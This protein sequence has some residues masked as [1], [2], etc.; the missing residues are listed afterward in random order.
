MWSPASRRRDVEGAR[1]DHDGDLALVVQVAAGS[2]T[3][4]VAAVAVQRRHG[5][6]EVR[7]RRAERRLELRATA[8]IV[9]MHADDLARLGRRQVVRA[10][11]ATRSP[12]TV[13]R[14]FPSRTTVVGNPWSAILRV[15]MPRR[16]GA[17]P[18][19][20]GFWY[21]RTPRGESSLDTAPALALLRRR[22]H[23]RVPHRS[24]RCRRVAAA[25]HRTGRRRSR[26]RRAG[27]R[28]LAIVRRRRCR[29]PRPGALPVQGGVRRRPLPAWGRDLLALCLDLGRQGF[30]ARARLVPGLPQEA[31]IDLDDAAGHGR[32]SRPEARARR[33]VRGDARRERPSA[34]RR[35]RHVDAG[36]WDR[37]LRERT[38]DAAFPM[39]AIDRGRW[40]GR[41]RRPRDDAVRRRGGRPGV[42]RDRHLALYDTRGRSSRRSG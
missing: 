5:L 36:G 42:A 15:S 22:P 13:T 40:C 34:R 39:V 32:E 29:A 30:R 21:P 41:A 26:C 28:R 37:R 19:L 2:R 24:R 14:S 6:V 33:R 20:G 9:E 7:R 3:D 18:E 38:A 10:S 25:R 35:R 16:I 8:L 1:A 4:D 12:S 31:R 11:I 27:L 23:D 17:M